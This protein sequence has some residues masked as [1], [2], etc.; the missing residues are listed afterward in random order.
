M[1]SCHSNQNSYLTRTKTQ[2]FMIYQTSSPK[3]QRLLT[4]EPA[5]KA[6]KLYFKSFQVRVLFRHARAG[7]SV[8]GGLIRPKFEHI[9]EIMHGIVTCKF[10]KIGTL[11]DISLLQIFKVLICKGRLFEKN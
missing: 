9:Q 8:V 2:L 3:R 6:I 10:K 5:S 7:N 4:Y 11:F 1:I